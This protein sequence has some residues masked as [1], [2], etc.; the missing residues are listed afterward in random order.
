[1][2]KDI[3]VLQRFITNG[4]SLKIYRDENNNIIIDGDILI[5]ETEYTKFPVKI[6]KV[7]GNISWHGLMN[8]FKFGNLESLE[9]FPEI[10][11]GSVY[12][13]KNPK[14]KSLKGCPKYIGQSL[15]CDHC[16][17]SDITDIS[18][19]IGQNLILA[20]NP[21][22]DVSILENVYVGNL[23]NIIRTDIDPF[24]LKLKNDSSIIIHDIEYDY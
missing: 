14:I 1:M 4:K 23:V 6:H 3:K 2:D 10:V 21:I 7:N 15:Q 22:K 5:F 11:T 8:G 24:T 19:Y 9:N 16:N 18:E 20:N 12:I 17:I 13:Q